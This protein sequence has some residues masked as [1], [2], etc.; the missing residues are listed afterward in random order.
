M[1]Q[2]HDLQ[3]LAEGLLCGAAVADEEADKGGGDQARLR[4]EASRGREY[5]ATLALLHVG[6]RTQRLEETLLKMKT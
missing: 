5:A 6:E 4:C 3:A 2:G 1:L